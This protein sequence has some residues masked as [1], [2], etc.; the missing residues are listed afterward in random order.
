MKTL[1]LIMLIWLGPDDLALVTL[2]GYVDADECIT[3]LVEY[4]VDFNVIEA[5][6]LAPVEAEV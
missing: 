5:V 6:C 1:I 3:E 2:E 4:A